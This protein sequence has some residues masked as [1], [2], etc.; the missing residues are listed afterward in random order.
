MKIFSEFFK[1]KPTSPAIIKSK[2]DSHFIGN[3]KAQIIEHEGL[4]LKPYKDSVGV[5]TIGVGRNLEHKGI[6]ED[7]AKFLFQNDLKDA[8]RDAQKY[9]GYEWYLQ[10]SNPRKAAL[11]DMAFNLGLTRL[12]KFKKTRELIIEAIQSGDFSQVAAN[13][14]TTLWYKQVRTRAVKICKQWET[15]EWQ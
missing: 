15:G 5:L 8:M 12:N 11:I 7:E 10:L 13:L 9:L 1:P 3:L 4:R 6:S 14:E 2:P